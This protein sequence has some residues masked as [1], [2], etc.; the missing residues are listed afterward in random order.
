MALEQVSDYLSQMTEDMSELTKYLGDNHR[1]LGLGIGAAVGAA[2]LG[3]YLLSPPRSLMEAPI[4]LNRQSVEVP[5]GEYAR[6]SVL[7]EDGKLVE[8]LSG[9]VN[10][11][12]EGFQRGLEMSK[13]NPCLGWRT[14]PEGPFEW[15]TYGNV[16]EKAHNFGS[17][18]LSRGLQSNP[19][20]FLGI[21]SQNRV[22][23]TVTEQAC[24]MYSMVIVPLYD[25]LG[26]QAVTYIVNQAKL[27]TIV[28][29]KSDKAVKLLQNEG[30]SCVKCIIV[31]DAISED[32]RK[33]AEECHV[34][35]VPFSEVEEQGKQNL[36]EAVPPKPD[37]LC[38]ICYTSGTTGNPKGA[39]LSH[40]N[41]VAACAGVAVTFEQKFKMTPDDVHISYLPLAHIF[42]RLVQCYLFSC[43][44]RIGFFQGDVRKLT[45]DIKELRP[46]IFATVPR[47]LNRIYDKVM[48]GA[49]SAGV[50][51]RL[52]LSVAL[53]R[54]E[55][56]LNRGVF[57]NDTLWDKVVFK[58][59]QENLGGR[60]K[61]IVTG[62]A[63]LSPTIMTFLRCAMGCF[64]FEGYGQT[65]S[66]AA[67]S[68][69]FPMD[70]SVGHVGIPVACVKIKLDDVP[71]MNYYAKD[72]KGE[73]CVKGASV[74]KGYLHEPEKTAETIDANGWLHT[75]DIGTWTPQGTLKIIDR[76]K[77]IFKLAQGEYIAPEKIEGVYLRS[78]LVGQVFVHGESLQACLVGVVVPDEVAFPQLASSKGI[79]GDMAELCKNA[80]LKKEVMDSIIALGK[81]SSLHSFEQVKD[82]YLCPEPFS[83]ENGLLTPTFKSKRPQLRDFFQ[84]QITEM[85][86]KLT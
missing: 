56:A 59:I 29:D 34:E 1:A 6:V 84:D 46:T 80:A 14:S 78:P 62:A 67:A 57:N 54:K 70:F 9:N 31:M 85:Y 72:G 45:D 76:K 8:T 75:G 10:T 63:P 79:T 53:K 52:L 47:L 30:I 25:T 82:L 61:Y 36:Q 28:C 4:D 19:E 50:V 42:E 69:T 3:Y 11:L 65:E 23:W 49:A 40:K 2:T 32:A 41:I 35:L 43:G 33:M 18:L 66:A 86:S 27:S 15:M 26:P 83:V 58:K 37:D 64:V 77:H 20:T 39:M 16:A 51:K 68:L 38:T 21:F 12:Y 17:G 44:A 73:I 48:A 22:E 55:A 5:G 60:V 13:N 24:N 71:D 81:K 7:C 74:F